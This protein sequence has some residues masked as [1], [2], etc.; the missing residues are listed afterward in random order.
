MKEREHIYNINKLTSDIETRGQLIKENLS[1]QRG[2]IS[3][4]RGGLGT[5]MSRFPVIDAFVGRIWQRRRRDVI[6]LG[7]FIAICFIVVFFLWK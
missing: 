5:M 1:V 3:S 2:E 4:S 7:V 6:I